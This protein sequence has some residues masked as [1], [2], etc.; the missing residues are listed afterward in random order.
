MTNVYI[1]I[2]ESNIK[3]ELKVMARNFFEYRKELDKNF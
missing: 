3:L 2:V 1:L